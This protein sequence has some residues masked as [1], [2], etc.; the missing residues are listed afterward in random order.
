MPNTDTIPVQKSE[1]DSNIVKYAELDEFDDIINH[2]HG[3]GKISKC[4]IVN[5]TYCIIT[6]L[7]KKYFN[8]LKT[9]SKCGY[10]LRVRTGSCYICKNCGESNGCS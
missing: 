8:T 2:L 1:N 7:N 4:F 3:L 5:F 6:D 10:I 9:C